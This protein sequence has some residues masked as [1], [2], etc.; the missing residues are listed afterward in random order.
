MPYQWEATDVTNPWEGSSAW[1]YFDKN[2]TVCKLYRNPQTHCCIV[3]I[4]TITKA[5]F[6]INT[7]IAIGSNQI[8][9]TYKPKATATS[10]FF[11]TNYSSI[12]VLSKNATS[13]ALALT[14][15]I[16]PISSGT[17]I[18]MQIEWHYV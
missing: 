12:V 10:T 17:A 8:L 5:E 15:L 11:S 7:S 4:N 9:N 16:S 14:A 13:E 2:N 6:P 3:T 1:N 18:E